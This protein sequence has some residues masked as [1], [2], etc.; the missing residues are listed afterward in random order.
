MLLAWLPKEPAGQLTIS[1]PNH[2][3]CHFVSALE[4]VLVDQISTTTRAM[5]LSLADV[6][7]SFMACAW[8]RRPTMKVS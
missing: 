7:I 8:C 4:D 5:P 1:L 6:N 2:S 3:L